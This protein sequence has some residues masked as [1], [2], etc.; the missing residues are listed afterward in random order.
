MWSYKTILFKQ[1][2]TIT[3]KST[4]SEPKKV[5]VGYSNWG[6]PSNS[7][8]RGHHREPVK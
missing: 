3:T 7:I 6:N 8:V 5:I 1:K 4:A 2:K